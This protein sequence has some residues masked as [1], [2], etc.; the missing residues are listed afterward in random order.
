MT[1]LPNEDD[2]KIDIL[3]K[4]LRLE[5]IG[6]RHTSEKN[7]PK[8]FP[9]S[10]WKRVRKVIE[11]LSKEG[12]FIHKPKKDSIHVSLNPDKIHQIKKEIESYRLRRK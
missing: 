3:R 2:I 10:E 7:L 4:M 5:Y 12:Y 1:K 9:K 11:H 6:G 8:G